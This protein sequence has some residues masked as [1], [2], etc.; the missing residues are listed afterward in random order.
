VPISFGAFEALWE[1]LAQVRLREAAA[2]QA[3]SAREDDA[4]YFRGPFPAE[5]KTREGAS[6][7]YY[8]YAGGVARRCFE[9][10]ADHTLAAP[11]D[12]VIPENGTD[13]MLGAARLGVD[14]DGEQ[15][16]PRLRPQEVGHG[17]IERLWEQQAL[18]R[19][20]VLAELPPSTRTS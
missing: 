9:V 12:I 20:R 18:P 13:D 8:E 16:D 3:S 19:L 6:D 1:D 15:I 17:V 4:Y 14:E 7:I 5:L 11:F 2:T 10:F